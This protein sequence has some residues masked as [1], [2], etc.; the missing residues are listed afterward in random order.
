MT[1]ATWPETFWTTVLAILAAYIRKWSGPDSPAPLSPEE[2]DEIRSRIIMDVMAG[3]PGE[4][5]P[6]HY[7]FRVARKWRIRQWAG[8][9]ETDRIRKRNERARARASLR[10]P[11]SAEAESDRNKSPF[12]GASM[13]AKT[14]TPLAT[15]IA[16]ESAERGEI[17]YV[18][19]R[20]RKAR[21]KAV[22]GNPG[23]TTYRVI[24]VGHVGR[25]RA[26]FSPS[27]RSLWWPG[28]ATRIAYV[29]IPATAERGEY[30]R[31]ARAYRAAVGH[32]GSVPNREI[33]KVK[34][35]PIPA[36][37]AAAAFTGDPEGRTFTRQPIP[38]RCLPAME[39][40]RKPIPADRLERL[41]AGQ[42]DGR[43]R[44]ILR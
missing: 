36:S 35:D 3:D 40:T 5:T 31:K 42:Y 12:R 22:K 2:R 33:G 27:G 39:S 13:D 24:V 37:L 16:A 32:V 21:R 9:C 30:C 17:R 25:P 10:D 38:T 4:L 11:G 23:P 8:D 15:M 43:S 7:V 1:P 19:D 34:A 18:S 6:L 26:G 44:V 29:A 14:P 41:A 28:S 20:Q